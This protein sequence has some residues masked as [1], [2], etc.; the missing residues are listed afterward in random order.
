MSIFDIEKKSITVEDL[1]SL[2][3]EYFKHENKWE[4]IIRFRRTDSERTWGVRYYQKGAKFNGSKLRS[5]KLD[6]RVYDI[7]NF[8]KKYSQIS[9]KI[10]NY[11]WNR[12]ALRKRLNE[13]MPKYSTVIIRNPDLADLKSAV[14]GFI[15]ENW[16]IGSPYKGSFGPL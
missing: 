9:E 6:I 4:L 7:E 5:S 3:F 10:E 14:G 16:E 13:L 12:L 11:S 1:K 8:D 15:N 2:G